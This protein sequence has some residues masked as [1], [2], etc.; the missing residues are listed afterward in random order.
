MATMLLI[1]SG[2]FIISQ[3]HD[4]ICYFFGDFFI[5]LF[6]YTTQGKWITSKD[7]ADDFYGIASIIFCST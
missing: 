1:D 2:W 6:S 3:S 7:D 5:S 4:W